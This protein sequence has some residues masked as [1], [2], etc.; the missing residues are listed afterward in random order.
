[1]DEIIDINTLFGPQPSSSNDLAVDTLRVLM[2]K[3]QVRAACTI[4]TLG[5]LLDSDVGNAATN[6]ACSE[7]PELIPVGTLNPT[8][9]LGDPAGVR[10]LSDAGFHMIRFFPSEQGWAPD[11]APFGEILSVLAAVRLPVMVNIAQ[12]GEVTALVRTLSGYPGTVIL[13]EVAMRTLP[14]ALTALRQN[15]NWNMEISHLLAPG[16]VQAVLESVGADRLLFGTGAPYHPIAGALRT[17]DYSGLDAGARAQILS[18]NARR[19]LPMAV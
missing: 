13:S 2:Q 4:S 1:M 11:Y 14:E 9:Y 12:I 6:A 3:H 8:R 16:C 10:R 7:H 15:K 19:L 18:A 5:V 17:L